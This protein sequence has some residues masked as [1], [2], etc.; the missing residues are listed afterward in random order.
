MGKKQF[1]VV[2][3][4]LVL[5]A[6]FSVLCVPD[7]CAATTAGTEG[8]KIVSFST[9]KD[10]Y[11]ANEQMSVLLSV[12]A[13]EDIPDVVIEVEGVKSKSGANKVYI[14]LTEN[15]IAGENLIN[16]SQ[17]L[18]PCSSCAGISQ[19]T[20]FIEAKLTH[21]ED[22]VT[23]THSIA[24]TSAPNQ[25]IP[26]NIMVEETK[27]L[28]DTEAQTE[29]LVMVDVRNSTEY[30]AA[31]IRG[32]RSVPISELSNR[33]GEFNKSSKIVVYTEDGQNGTI[34]CDLLIEQGFER[35]YN[36]IGGLE[37]WNES[38]YPVVSTAEEN[39]STPGFAAVLA[40]AALLAVAFC[41]RRRP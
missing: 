8:I 26:V 20:Y 38:G 27:R 25:R 17:K 36:V 32:A 23:A 9:D 33:T 13:P 31:H 18:P 24:I 41:P 29:A 28:I 4:A 7:G 22:V 14:K 15:L 21:G 10:I 1:A 3:T 34:A 35:V 39:P 12:Y 40:L 37:A 2:F 16:C 5:A 19:G 11:S 6:A 30:D